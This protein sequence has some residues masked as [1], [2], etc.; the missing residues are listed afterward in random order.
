MAPMKLLALLVAV[1]ALLVA[2]LAPSAYAD[3][4]AV[5]SVEASGAI[6]A[7]RFLGDDHHHHG[8]EDH[9]HD[10]HH[11]DDHHKKPK[12][13]PKPS[14]P[15]SPPKPKLTCIQKYK[16][17]YAACDEKEKA[18]VAKAEGADE[19]KTCEAKSTMCE[20]K[21]YRSFKNC[22][23]GKWGCK[24][25]CLYRRRQCLKWYKAPMCEEKYGECV[26]A[27]KPKP[28]PSPK[29]SPP[30]KEHH[31][32]HEHHK[33]HDHHDDHHHEHHDD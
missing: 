18:C 12:P 27:C 8:D 22:K 13:K 28:K 26:E 5:S 33:H 10:D 14:P 25:W 15:P 21:A 2:L 20:R 4:S 7:R 29:P 9:H 32:H 16:I 30:K 11:D 31:D 1:S 17:K 24:D 23:Y 3:S 19:K 6:A